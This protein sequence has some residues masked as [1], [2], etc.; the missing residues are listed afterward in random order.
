MK[1]YRT[2]TRG[3]P[4]SRDRLL[5]LAD[6]AFA[7]AS[8]SG[9]V[10]R[11]AALDSLSRIESGTDDAEGLELLGMALD[12]PR[13]GPIGEAIVTR[14]GRWWPGVTEWWQEDLYAQL[15][16]WHPTE[17]LAETLQLALRGD[18]NQLA[19]A[20][21]LARVF[22][23]NPEIR[24]K[25]I[26][27]THE[28]VNPW[29]TAAALDA[30]SRGWPSIDG[31]DNWLH[32]AERSPS[33]QL[34]TVS[35]LALYRRGRRGDEGR[36]SLLRALGTGWSRFTGSLHA[37][38]M[39]ALLADWADDS[40]L[41]DACWAR[42]GDARSL[43]IRH[44][45]RQRPFDAHEASPGRSPRATLG[46]GGNRN[47]RNYFPFRRNAIRGRVAGTNPVRTCERACGRLI[48]GSRGWNSQVTTITVAQLAAMLRSD[49][50]K[51]A[52]LS[53][54]AE[55][56]PFRFWPV[57]SLLHGWGIDDPEVAAA[58]DPLPRIPPEERQHIA[59]HVPAIV[60]IGRREAF[61][62]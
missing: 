13:A 32:E 43:D 53:W 27:L 33:I 55:K 38:I 21:S 25:L 26:A 24:C 12:G 7:T 44:R 34:R 5:L 48:L 29:V 22:G 59:H 57:W 52:M 31:L 35:A 51:R 37:E 54:L 46:T 42:L 30:L 23:G 11:Q 40:K 45:L 41:Q 15:G 28:S 2:N 9:S 4:D 14:L 49:E 47:A 17:E 6:G 10:G 39:D 58:L 8:L 20:S 36:D 18:S 61:G 19:A 3:R 1:R 62:Y 50:A 60:G 56:G 16:R